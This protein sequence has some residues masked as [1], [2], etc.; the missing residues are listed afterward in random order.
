MLT[1][2][3]NST[4]LNSK[5]EE[6]RLGENLLH[7]Y[8]LRGCLKDITLSLTDLSHNKIYKMIQLD[9]TFMILHLYS[10]SKITIRRAKD[11]K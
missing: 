1:L 9:I 7:L 5:L 10:L 3:V 4:N 8:L 6:I 11:Y 2:N